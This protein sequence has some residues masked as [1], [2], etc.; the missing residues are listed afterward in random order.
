MPAVGPRLAGEGIDFCDRPTDQ[1]VLSIAQARKA[2]PPGPVGRPP[3]QARPRGPLRTPSPWSNGP[4]NA[5]EITQVR[6]TPPRPNPKLE[7]PWGGAP[8]GAG[9]PPTCDGRVDRAGVTEAL[10][11]GVSDQ[12]DEHGSRQSR[13]AADGGGGGTCADEGGGGASR[14]AVSMESPSQPECH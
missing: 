10:E 4:K 5:L 3:S 8:Q 9:D 2:P 13:G 11:N 12:V 6:K 7:E 14:R 1:P